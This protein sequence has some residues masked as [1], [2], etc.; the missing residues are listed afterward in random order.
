MLNKSKVELRKN[1]Q[2]IHSYTLFHSHRMLNRPLLFES[3]LELVDSE[4]ELVPGICAVAA[5]GH[6]PGHMALEICSCGE[7][8]LCISDAAIHPIHLEQLNWYA[9]FDLEP[10]Q[11]IASRQRLVERAFAKNAL[12]HASHFPFPGLGHVIQKE[13]KWHW[14]PI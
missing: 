13:D 2:N 10:K 9:L 1:Y 11:S 6:T 7:Q 8:L 4:T 14:Q 5:Q 12:V 3:Q